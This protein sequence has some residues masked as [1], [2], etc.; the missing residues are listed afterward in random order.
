VERQ[1]RAIERIVTKRQFHL[2]REEEQKD[3][4]DTAGENVSVNA[5]RSGTGGAG[6]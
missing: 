2:T 1:L 3:R 5:W 6:K 4:E